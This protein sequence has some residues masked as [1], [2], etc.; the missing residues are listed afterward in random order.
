MMR[1]RYRA[2]TAKMYTRAIQGHIG[3][4][5]SAPELMGHV[6]IP[7]NW[8]EFVFH[9]GCSLN[10]KSIFETGPIARGRASNE[11]RQTISSHLSTVVVKSQMKKNA[12]TIY[13]RQGKCITTAIGSMTKMLFFLVHLS[14][15]QDQG[16]Q[17]WQTKSN[18][19]FIHDPVPA[20]CIY[21]L[22][23]QIGDRILFE[24]LHTST[25]TTGNFLE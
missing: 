8:K 7:Y 19:I 9:L 25:C 22:I 6:A 16:L 23:S 12:V 21:R 20:D 13:Q 11:G 4:N 14:P 18:A 1:S 15:A 17:F 3:G 10:I 2:F 24:R 5:M